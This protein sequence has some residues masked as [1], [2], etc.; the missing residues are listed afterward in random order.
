MKLS[1]LHLGKEFSLVDHVAKPMPLEHGQK[2]L[3]LQPNYVNHNQRK[4]K[5]EK[6]LK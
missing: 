3:C 5:P 4:F 1:A 2:I 6:A